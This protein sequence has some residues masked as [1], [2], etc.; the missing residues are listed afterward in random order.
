MSRNLIIV[1]V[2]L[3][4]VILGMLLAFAFCVGTGYFFWTNVI[5]PP[6]GEGPKAEAGYKAGAPI[7]D[8][9]E[10]YKAEHNAY[11]E[12]LNALVPDFLPDHLANPE[13]ILFK[14]QIKDP[15]YELEFRY[16]VP[17]MN[18]CTYTP[19]AGWDCYGYY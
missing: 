15:S 17:G 2:L 13:D 14:Y 11:P 16:A 5:G 7:I 9:L 8:A 6:P 18:I 4:I 19:E 3:G 1:L 10:R 12:T